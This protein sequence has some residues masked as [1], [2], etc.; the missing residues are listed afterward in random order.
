MTGA[1]KSIFSKLD[2]KDLELWN[3]V[4]PYARED[5]S[6]FRGFISRLKDFFGKQQFRN[7]SGKLT[8]SKA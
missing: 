2:C 8:T 1:H 4:D 7:I 6:S 3:L 5:A